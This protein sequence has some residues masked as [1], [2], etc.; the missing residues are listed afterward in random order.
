MNSLREFRANARMTAY[1]RSG[2]M[3]YLEEALAETVAQV[4]VN[5]P[6]ASSFIEGLRFPIASG[7][8]T[9]SRVVTEAAIGTI[10]YGG[11]VYGIYVTFHDSHEGSAHAHAPEEQSR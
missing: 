5:G 8:V 1:Q 9:L 4:K 7:Y 10:A 11:I 6:R 3:K 2:L